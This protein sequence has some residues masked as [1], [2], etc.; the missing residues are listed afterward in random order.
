M[1]RKYVIAVDLDGT[2]AYHDKW[3]DITHIGA[4]IPAM[5]E[6]VKGWL[7]QGHEVLIFT[8][9]VDADHPEQ[10]YLARP[11]IQAWC[12]LHL[13]QILEITA[14]KSLRFDAFY[15]DRAVTIEANTGRPLAP[16]RRGLV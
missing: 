8:A 11:A 3:V 9:R 10:A 2:L 4:P 16:C 13:G 6:R 14:N 5:V 1:K 7:G 12:M 15:D